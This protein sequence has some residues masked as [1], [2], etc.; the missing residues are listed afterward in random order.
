MLL[1]AGKLQRDFGPNSGIDSKA[2]SAS[3]C[4]GTRQPMQ[5][6]DTIHNFAFG[7]GNRGSFL[8]RQFQVRC[9]SCNVGTDF[10][11]IGCVYVRVWCLLKTIF[12]PMVSRPCASFHFYE[13][14]RFKKTAVGLNVSSY[15]FAGCDS[16]LSTEEF[17]YG[18]CTLNDLDVYWQPVAPREWE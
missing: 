8:H 7:A 6:P 12:W 13:S 4:L 3:G 15:D 10:F 17:P 16:F 18:A 2:S 11:W 5:R 14:N 9:C 1:L